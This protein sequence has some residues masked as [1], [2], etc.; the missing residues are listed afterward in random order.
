M[1]GVDSGSGNR[2]ERLVYA[3]ADVAAR[4]GVSGAGLRRLA[5]VYERVH[6]VLGRDPRLGRVWPQEAVERLE[7]ARKIVRTGRA[8]SVETALALL[9]SG[10]VD[11]NYSQ[12]RPTLGESHSVSSQDQVLEG[13][14]GELRAL[15]QAV[16][17]QNRHLYV[18]E[19][20]NRQFRAALLP[21]R[22]ATNLLGS[23][24]ELASRFP[25]SREADFPLREIWR[26]AARLTS[27]RRERD[28]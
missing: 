2:E 22:E 3:P 14:M 26:F 9:A 21:S 16:E 19:Q 6:G 8:M 17:E 7:R 25:S 15:R 5:V 10:E 27:R 20:E 13:L 24:R 1:F 28:R 12:Q 18:L 11:P 23:L 4:L